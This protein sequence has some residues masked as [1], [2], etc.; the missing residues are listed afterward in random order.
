MD[1]R[2]P[3]GHL[4]PLPALTP[5]AEARKSHDEARLLWTELL[6]RLTHVAEVF[7]RPDIAADLRTRGVR[8]TDAV[9]ASL[10]REYAKA[11]QIAMT[12]GTSPRP[13][14]V[15][16]RAR[17]LGGHGDLQQEFLALAR[18]YR[19]LIQALALPA[20]CH[21]QRWLEGRALLH[22]AQADALLMPR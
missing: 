17:D 14:E 19:Q 10:A 3:G 13:H 16:H 1:D 4:Q 21:R 5:G 6:A 12:L 15:M 2:G 20:D 8:R 22:K 7:A 9:M 11:G 18:G